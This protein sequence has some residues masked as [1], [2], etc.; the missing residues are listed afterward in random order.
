MGVGVIIDTVVSRESIGCRPEG[1]VCLALIRRC[2]EGS[3]SGSSGSHWASRY[4]G[5]PFFS[6]SKAV[7]QITLFFP[8]PHPQS[9]PHPQSVPKE[10]HVSPYQKPSIKPPSFS[11]FFYPH[12]QSTSHPQFASSSPFSQPFENHQAITIYAD[13]QHPLFISSSFS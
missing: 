6:L 8:N 7:N 10:P 13:N 3:C 2:F 1:I 9:T 4:V 5:A 12:L 11:F